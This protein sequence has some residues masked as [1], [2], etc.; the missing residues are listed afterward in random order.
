MSK[1]L[2]IVESPAKAKTIGKILGHDYL[3]RASM[4]HIRDLPERAFGV[5]IEHGFL[6]QYEES[7]S[8]GRNLS[9]LKSAAREAGEIYLASDPD[10]EGEAIAWHLREVLSKLNKKA[11]FHRVSFHEITRSAIDRAFRNPGDVDMNLVDAQQARRVLDRIVGYQISP[12]LWTRIERGVSAGRVQSVALRLVCERE[13]EIRAFVPQEY[14]TFPAEFLPEGGR[15]SFVA[16]LQKINEGK[17]EIGNGTDA[18]AVIAAIRSAAAWKVAAIDVQPKRRFAPPPFI[19]STLQQAAGAALG[20]SASQTMRIAQQLYEGVD[21]GRGPVGLITYMRTDSVAVAVEAQNACRAFIASKMGQDFIPEKPN[22][23]R[24]KSSAQ[25]AHEAIRPTDVNLTPESL[26]AA[27][28]PQQ[29]K[30]YSIIWRRFV[31]S[32]MAPARQER[33]SVDVSGRGGDG[34]TYTFRASATVTKF[35]G[36]LRAYNVAEEEVSGDDDEDQRF[37]AV[38]ALLRQGQAC[39]LVRADSEQ[40][41]TEPAPRYSEASLIKELE[42]NGIGR[43][44]TYATIVN[45]IQ[46]RKYVEKEKGKLIPTDL[47]FRINDYLVSSLPEL[48]QVGFTADMEQKLDE[49]EEGKHQW[50]QMLGEFYDKFHR[51]LQSAKDEGAPPSEKTAALI[52]EIGRIRNWEK[53]ERVPGKR[54]FN[55]ERFVRSVKEKYE[56]DSKISSR[57]WETLL[58]LAL[59]YRDQL[60]DLEETAVRGGFAEDLHAA[61]AKRME[62]EAER[63]EWR[64]QREEADK[65]APPQENIGKIF[66]A[67]KQVKWL[68]PEKRRGREYDDEK[69]FQSLKHQ[70]DSGRP[71]SE[72]QL[73]ALGRI[74]EKYRDQISDPEKLSPILGTAAPVKKEL[75]PDVQNRVRE[76]FRI[77]DGVTNWAEP[78]KRGRRVY[79]D[80]EFVQSIRKQIGQGRTLSPKQIAAMEKLAAKYS[81]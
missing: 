1:K 4:G 33:T 32:Q 9:E 8:R 19:T 51:W 25:G 37:A 43:P 59:R 34:R 7:K 78:V 26:K 74:F 49:V 40:K 52:R 6:P 69:F 44:S 29:F 30:L 14:W 73:S 21:I 61:D 28:D 35:P 47:G 13:R 48:F 42:T 50:T 12:L 20:F 31:A 5:D 60:P 17:C 39:R 10:R 80:R 22:V 53:P 62:H 11:R 66:E 68:P 65:A 24:S 41:F 36:F 46:V 81:S 2:V 75:A 79:D 57:Q 55:G 71:L 70:A 77:F 54:T 56:K 16:K 38:L 18:A 76:L 15:D 58:S 64:H 27:L 63:A 67:M 3:I 45:T 72:K 23:F